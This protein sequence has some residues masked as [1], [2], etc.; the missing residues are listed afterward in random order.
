MKEL[1]NIKLIKLIE[2]IRDDLSKE[3]HK[4]VKELIK[5]PTKHTHLERVSF[6]ASLDIFDEVLMKVLDKKLI[7]IG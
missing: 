4:E 7:E 5:N 3:F 2:E 1:N 6:R